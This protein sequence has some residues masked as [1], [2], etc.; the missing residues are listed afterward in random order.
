L[1][2]SEQGRIALEALRSRR[3]DWM[4]RRVARLTPEQMDALAAAI[5]PLMEIAKP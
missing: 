4:A 2:I 1:R 5:G 3:R